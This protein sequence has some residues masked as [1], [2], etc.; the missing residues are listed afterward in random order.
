MLLRTSGCIDTGDLPSSSYPLG[1]WCSQVNDLP[2]ETSLDLLCNTDLDVQ[3][4]SQVFIREL[5]TALYPALNK[6]HGVELTDDTWKFSI[7]TYLRVLTPLLVTR[8]NLVRRTIEQR[9]CAEFTFLGVKDEHVIPSDRSQL[10]LLVNSH[11]WNQFVLEQICLELELKPLKTAQLDI[12]RTLSPRNATHPNQDRTNSARKCAQRILNAIARRRKS[13]VIQTM[14]PSLAEFNVALSTLSVPMF[15]HGDAPYSSTIDEAAR[16]IILKRV[17]TSDNIHML[18]REIIIRTLPK[19][20][21]ED[22]NHIRMRTK[23][24]F[25][26]QPSLVF[27]SNLHMAS[28]QFLLWLSEARGAKTRV[29]IGQ[30]GGVH[31]LARDL[32]VEASIEFELADRYL[33]WGEFAS[34]VPRG[35]KSPALVT[36][37]K[38]LQRASRQNSILMILDSPYR[39]PSMPRGLNANRFQYSSMLNTLLTKEFLNLAQQIVIRQY[40][41]AERFDD[42]L[43]ELLTTDPKICSDD[44]TQP[45][46]NLLKESRLVIATSLGT[47]PF[48][49]IQNNIPTMLLLDPKFS[50][51][52]VWAEEKFTC[53]R[54]AS[55]LF[56]DPLDLLN[57]FRKVSIDIDQWWNSPETQQARRD[58]VNLFHTQ[59]YEKSAFYIRQIRSIRNSSTS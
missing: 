52:S 31:C 6:F 37:G 57:Q 49:T 10:Q 23:S 36:R 14:L 8:Y 27:T 12:P 56:S 55:M 7:G 2:C 15:W 4:F 34:Q 50:P 3:E 48:R 9:N 20:F 59:P 19:L 40:A 32:P 41:G 44:G 46:E 45:I 43:L 54:S 17:E 38:N 51:L 16:G 47:T 42:S 26:K 21:V 30:H 1:P 53:L 18:F 22:F 5:E 33:A 28:D 29:M 24:L 13:V 25:P 39:Y 58:F 11:L 35:V